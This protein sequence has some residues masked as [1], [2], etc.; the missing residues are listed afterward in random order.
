MR[1]SEGECRGY[2]RLSRARR[3]VRSSPCSIP[4]L[5]VSRR[6]RKRC[7]PVGDA[8]IAGDDLVVADKF[9]GRSPDAI[10]QHACRH[11]GFRDKLLPSAEKAKEHGQVVLG[12]RG[13][14]VLFSSWP[15]Y[16]T[17]WLQVVAGGGQQF[18]S[19]EGDCPRR[20]FVVHEERSRRR[21]C[22]F[23]FDLAV[24]ERQPTMPPSGKT[25]PDQMGP[26]FA[27]KYQYCGDNRPRGSTRLCRAGTAMP[28]S[29]CSHCVP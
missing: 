3:G 21:S 19:G 18:R 6:C 4:K 7:L 1:L 26:V 8:A 28:V 14:L 27:F 11:C 24:V 25:P 17:V 13:L 16:P 22:T 9:L 2:R 29:V 23:K 5:R 12:F 10:S 15:S 20:S